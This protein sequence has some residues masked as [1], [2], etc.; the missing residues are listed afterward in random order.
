LKINSKIVRSFLAVALCLAI[1]APR[2]FAGGNERVS[3]DSLLD[4]QAAAT[5]QNQITC[6]ESA[7]YLVVAKELREEIGTD[8]LIKYRS[9]RSEKLECSYVYEKEYFEI[10]NEWAEYFAGLKGD[11]LI[12]D[13]TTGPGP[14]GLIIWDLVKRKKVY[15]DS[16]S[17][18]EETKDDTLV[19]WTET[20]EATDS[21]C[22][23]LEKWKSQGFEA[24]VETKVILNLTNF[25]IT[26]TPQTRCSARQ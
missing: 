16:W 17:G 11:L 18:A 10:K 13:S 1:C 21:N 5:E 4:K 19:Y 14:S 7:K 26:K 22:P 20:G 8:F 15:E 12:L 6:Y 2:V 24:A 23:E 9:N 3:D 25:Q